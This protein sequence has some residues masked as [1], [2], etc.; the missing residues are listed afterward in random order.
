MPVLCLSLQETLLHCFYCLLTSPYFLLQISNSLRTGAISF[1][2]LLYKFSLSLMFSIAEDWICLYV[3][4]LGSQ[5]A[6]LI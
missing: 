1:L 6:Y 5:C 4:F 2:G 3:H